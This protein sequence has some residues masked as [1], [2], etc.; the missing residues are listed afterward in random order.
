MTAR[1]WRILP[2]GVTLALLAALTLIS[3]DRELGE[4]LRA[5]MGLLMARPFNDL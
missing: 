5:Q 3:L 1:T 4:R 2:V